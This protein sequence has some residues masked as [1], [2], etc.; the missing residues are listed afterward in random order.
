MNLTI[1][2]LF[3]LLPLVSLANEGQRHSQMLAIINDEL[4][5]VAR[6]QRNARRPKGEFI[7]R[8]AE[9]YLEKA[10]LIRDQENK[11]YLSL[12]PKLRTK[13]KRREYFKESIGYFR[14]AQNSCNRLLKKFRRFK[15]KARVYY[16]LAHNAMEFQNRRKAKTY[17]RKV[18]KNSRPTSSININSTMALA[19]MYYNDHQYRKAIPLYRRIIKI[20]REDKWHTKHLHS[21]AWCYFRT[22]KISSALA[23]MKEVY[24]KSKK[25]KYVDMSALAAKDLATFYA[26][27]KRIDQAV[28]FFAQNSKNAVDGPLTM[29]RNLKQQGKL[30]QAIKV[31]K[32]ARQRATS[33]A[34]KI[35]IAMELL[36]VYQMYDSVREGSDSY[37]RTV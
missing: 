28:A 30:K 6:L 17:F 26:D 11:K 9:L 7:L 35:R 29:A 3:F 18:V 31:L 27:S 36:S 10:R 5:D 19:E 22:K 23:T 33:K 14:K 2:L 4:R 21:L 25:S 20:K 16:I 15:N 1:I 13:S 24:Y 37:R 8:E 34:D 12:N 32:S